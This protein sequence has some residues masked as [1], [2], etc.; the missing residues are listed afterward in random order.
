[1]G[2]ENDIIY[3]ILNVNKI[4]I[5]I[6]YILT[7]VKRK[8]RRKR[9]SRKLRKSRTRVSKR[10]SKRRVSR[11]KRSRK[12]RVSRKKI[13]KA[14]AAFAK[15]V[16]SRGFHNDSYK[17][18]Y[19]KNKQYLESLLRSA[20]NAEQ[21][22]INSLGDANVYGDTDKRKEYIKLIKD[23]KELLRNIETAARGDKNFATLDDYDKDDT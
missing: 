23:Q 7:V 16:G 5:Y 4:Y 3:F 10:N 2:I 11:K 20:L 8:S 1:M 12:R 9:K 19:L 18:I 17:E 15:G 21:Y 22:Y 14:G 13:Q 6:Y